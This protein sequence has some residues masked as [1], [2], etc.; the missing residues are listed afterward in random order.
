M[1]LYKYH[2]AELQDEVKQPLH[3]SNDKYKVYGNKVR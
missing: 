2:L 3:M 1:N